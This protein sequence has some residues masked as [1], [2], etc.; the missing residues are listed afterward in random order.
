[1]DAAGYRVEI[2]DQQVDASWE[3]TLERALAGRPL[4]VG[5]SAMTG[6][7]IRCGSA[8]AALVRS[9]STV[10]IVWGGVHASLLPEQTAAD[11][12]VDVVVFGEGE[13]TFLEVIRRLEA[14]RAVEGVAGTCFKMDGTV[15]MNPARPFLDLDRCPPLPYHLLEVERYVTADDVSERT[16]ELPTSRGCPHRCGFCYN[17]RFARRCW[18]TMSVPVILER[19]TDVVQRFR[20]T[21]VNFR[22]DNFF[23]D[24][25]RVQAICQGILERGLKIGWHADCRCDDFARYPE[26]F[27]HLLRES[28]LRALTFGAESGSQR[29]L[30]A[31]GKDISV[32]DILTAARRATQLGLIANFHFMTGFPDETEEDLLRTYRLIGTLLRGDRRRRIYGPALYTPYPGTSLYDRCLELGFRPPGDLAGWA[33]YH[34]QRLNLP[35]R[36]PAEARSQERAAWVAERASPPLRGWYRWWFVLRLELLLHSGRVGP[37]PERWLLAAAKEAR[38]RWQGFLARL[39]GSR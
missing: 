32:A 18:R 37:L 17:L 16:L 10:P 20:L 13:G 4:C 14:G 24:R 34:W 26:T 1:V 36:R 3:Q 29:T 23:T 8:A 5:I 38:R 15:R 39:G 21:G 7:Q 12:L 19:L 22:E 33:D 27:L 30:D 25:G 2:I 35:W 31:V 9:A 28:G 6:N 11:P